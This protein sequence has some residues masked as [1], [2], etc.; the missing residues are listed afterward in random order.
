MGTTRVVRRCEPADAGVTATDRKDPVASFSDEFA[1]PPVACEMDAALAAAG[2]VLTP[3]DRRAALEVYAVLQPL[4]A[5]LYE[6]PDA[7]YEVP[8][9]VFDANPKLR[10]WRP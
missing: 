2:L 5:A 8:A 6:V 1:E 3:E 7:R 10:A 9:L 4:V